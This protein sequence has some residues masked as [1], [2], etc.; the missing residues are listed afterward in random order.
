M[1]NPIRGEHS[2]PV[3]P[4]QFLIGLLSGFRAGWIY[5]PAAVIAAARQVGGQTAAAL[6]GVILLE[7]VGGLFIAWDM[8]RTLMILTPIFLLGV[9]FC[10]RSRLPVLRVLLPLCIV[11]NLILPA[12][13]VTWFMN[14]RLSSL[15]T[16]IGMYRNPPGALA[17]ENV[18]IAPRCRS[19]GRYGHRLARIRRD[20]GRGSRLGQGY[21]ERAV[22]R[23]KL[24]DMLGAE[25]DLN[26]AL[27][28]NDDYPIALLIRGQL[29]Q[30]RGDMKGATSD[31]QE[32]LR[33][34]TSD[35]PMREQAEQTLRE[36]LTQ[37]ERVE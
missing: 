6:T 2:A 1:R 30:A 33:R 18:C 20:G 21:V 23:V 9:W 27:R 15:A 5:M 26:A 32:T 36:L 31:V 11:A 16:E 7:G 24:N 12:E 19:R 14:P 34:T 10:E 13:H 4:L 28:L 17:R 35:W 3:V 25:A 8:S 22:A 29:R 37:S